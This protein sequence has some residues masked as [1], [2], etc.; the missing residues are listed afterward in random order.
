MQPSNLPVPS[1]QTTVDPVASIPAPP[2]RDREVKAFESIT[3]ET[4]FLELILRN[5]LRAA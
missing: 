5:P 1:E 3:S 4:K 2:M